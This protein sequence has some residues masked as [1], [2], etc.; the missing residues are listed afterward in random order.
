MPTD[1]VAIARAVIEALAG[2]GAVITATVIR[3]PGDG[4]VPLAAKLLVR[5]DGT[6]LGALDAGPL[7]AAVRELALAH[8][9]HHGTRLVRLDERYTEVTRRQEPSQFDVLLEAVEPPPALVIIGGGH[10]GRALC[11]LAAD[12][13]YTVTVIDDR[14]DYADPL[15]LPGASN[16]VADE[17][18]AALDREPIGPHTAV[19][20]VSRGHKQDEIGLRHA[21]IRPAGYIGMIGSK[22]RT[23]TVLQHLADEGL[24]RAALDAVHT[25][26]GLDIGA[27]TPEEIAVSILAEIILDR[28]GGSGRPMYYRRGARETAAAAEA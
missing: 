26:I 11:R 23:A 15:K 22:R 6:T 13:G 7:D 24:P 4:A 1:T 9:R 2:G 28:R 8:F 10:I 14:A 12:T 20:L 3:A 16:V 19:V 5:P 17:V 21:V 27:E 18:G 25:P